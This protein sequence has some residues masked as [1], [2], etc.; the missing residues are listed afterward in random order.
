MS[1]DRLNDELAR[2]LNGSLADLGYGVPAGK[3]MAA[4]KERSKAS[5]EVHRKPA[6]SSYDRRESPTQP[7]ARAAARKKPAVAKD[8]FWTGSTPSHHLDSLW[9]DVGKNL[10]NEKKR[11]LAD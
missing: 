7:I 5:E 2:S 4:A 11:V 8:N 6:A 10:M 3:P 9:Q 1:F